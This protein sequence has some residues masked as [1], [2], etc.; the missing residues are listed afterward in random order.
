MPEPPRAPPPYRPFE[1]KTG[2][3]Y[4]D[5]FTALWNDIH[6]P[7]NGYFSAEG[8][9]YHAIETLNAEAPDYGH[10]TTSE[11]YSY[12]VWLEAMYGKVAKDWSYLDAAW[13]SL[14]RNIIPRHDDQ[15]TTETYNAH[16]P[17]TYAPELDEPSQ[18]PS[19]LDPK[20]KVGADPISDELRKTYGNADIYGMHWILDVDNWYGF[21]N[22]AD[23]V[24]KPSYI[25]TFQRG[26][27]ESVFEALTQPCWDEF[28]FGGKYGFLDLFVKNPGGAGATKQWKYTA[29]PDADARAIQAIFWAKTWADESGADSAAALAPLVKKAAKMGDYLRYALFD[30]YFKSQGCT[31]VDCP[32]AL[33]DRGGAH[34]LLSWYYAWGG[35]ISKSGG[36]SWRIG[37][38]S[39][40]GGYQN[41][42]AAYTLAKVP[43]FQPASPMAARDWDISLGRQIE[44][45]R[46]LQ[47]AEGA[48][49]GGAANGWAGRYE[50]YPTGTRTFYGLGYDPQPVYHDPPSNSWFGFQVWSMDRVAQYYYVTGD[51]K[52]KVILER[53]VA[54]VVAAVKFKGDD[55]YA[56]PSTLEWTGQPQL[57]WSQKTQNFVLGDKAFNF[58]LH[59]RIK[60]WGN[61]AGVAS[62]T[63]R[64]LAYY[65]AKSGDKKAQQVAKQLLDR[66]WAKYRDAKG[67]A[68]PEARADYKRFNDPVSIPAGWTGKMPN[69]DVIDSAS[70]FLSIR[71]KYKQDP[72]WP[73]MQAF[74]GG[75]KSPKPPNFTYH[76]FWAEADIALAN[77]AYGMLFPSDNPAGKG[78]AAAK[79]AAS[80][81]APHQDKKKGGE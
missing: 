37:S 51:E 59:V 23:G 67:V 11:A 55:D 69:G 28:K 24:S 77:A 54:W 68:T 3:A 15:P 35:S 41:P 26:P 4:V 10:E 57:D 14:E 65:A 9:P 22:R 64:T 58:N 8:V 63:A 12:Y 80:K 73:K 72:D 79:D 76:R 31:T 5:R 43:G 21:G 25:N 18:Y 66:Q 36:W 78:R 60:S 74:L 27:Q 39:A 56:V 81:N 32:P 34:Y 46:W 19:P 45:Y 33:D 70:T 53:W 40:H 44:F 2:N 20:I 50:P 47:S 38:S 30:K 1:T 7:A 6:N 49:A 61:D 42:L 52:A 48:I 13:S 16:H 71:S 17:A 75:G 62:A 29:A